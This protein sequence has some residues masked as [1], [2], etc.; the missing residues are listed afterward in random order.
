MNKPF[1]IGIVGGS[2][3]GKTT[4]VKM[5]RHQFSEDELCILSLDDYYKPHG[6]QKRDANG[7]ENFDRPNSLYKKAFIRDLNLLLEGKTV[8][9]EEYT[10]N[11]DSKKPALLTFKPAPIIIVEGLFIFHYKKVNRLL[12][13]KVYLSAKENLKIIRRI[14]RDRIERNYPLDDVLYRYQHHVLPAYEKYIQPHIENA[15][16]IIKNN[17]NFN[18]GL[19]VMEGFIAN[20]LG[21]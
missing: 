18:M 2:G 13:L 1:V 6:K 3:S 21:K 17:S 10:F 8:T 20:K 11:N 14:T 9:R 4:F 12:D 19:Q 15:D 7:I 16:I 5:L